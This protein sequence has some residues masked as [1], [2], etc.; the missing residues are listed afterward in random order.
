MI[1]TVNIELVQLSLDALVLRLT[2]EQLVLNG[3]N[4]VGTYEVEVNSEV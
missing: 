3:S 4:Q 1:A 2:V